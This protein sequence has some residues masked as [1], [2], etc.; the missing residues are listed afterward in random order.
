MTNY[1]TANPPEWAESGPVVWSLFVLLAAGS[2]SLLLW[3][4]R[5]AGAPENGPPV[6]D[7]RNIAAGSGHSLNPP[8]TPALVRG[9]DIE[10]ARI[11][12]LVRGPGGG[13]VV[14]CGAGGLGKT[15]VAAEAASRARAAGK[16]VVWI[17][18]RENSAQLA[19][20]LTQA[21][22]VLGLPES[23]LEEARSGRAPLVDAVWEQLASVPGW[24]I[25][26]DNV[27][28]PSHVGPGSEEISGYRGW[29]R[30]EGAGVLLITSRDT[31]PQTW[32]SEA[33]LM[34][35]EP[36]TDQAGGE[37]LM[38]TTPR[39][40]TRPQAEALAVRLGGVPLALN[41]AGSYLSVPTSRHRTF[42]AYQRA[43]ETEFGD[44]L[45]ATHPRAGGDPEVAR[46]L[47]RHTWDLSLDQLHREGYALARP[48]LQ[49][50]ALFEPAPIPRA[51]ITPA[52]L[53]EVTGSEATAAMVDGA[54]AGLHRY[55]LLGTG[56]TAEDAASPGQLLLHPLVREVT[57]HTLTRPD[58]AEGWRT[59]LARHLVQAATDT[60]G[61]PGREGWPTARLLAPHLGAL[62]DRTCDQDFAATRLVL[63]DLGNTLCEAGAV[64]EELL[65]RQN[66]LTA[67]D[68]RLGADH[69]DTLTSHNNLANA[70]QSAG[71]YH[72]A[73]ELHRHILTTFERTLGPD[74][75]ATLASRSN[76]A[77]SL[78][79]I[80][81]QQQAAELYRRVLSDRERVQGPDHPDTLASRNN[82]ATALDSI[83]EHQQAVDLHR[84]NLADRER[85]LGPDHPRT[86]DSR[87]NLASALTGLGDHEQAGVLYGGVLSDRERIQGPDHPDTLR[88][89]GNVAISLDGIGEHQ[90]AADL[91]RESLTDLVRILGPDHPQTLDS[92]HNLAHTFS[93]LRRHQQAADLHRQN[94]SDRE[95]VLGPDHPD[96]LRSCNDL[97]N[98]LYY[99]GEDRQAVDLYRRNL[100]DRER[101]LGPDHPDTRG[102]RHNLTTAEASLGNVSSRHRRLPW[103]R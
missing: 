15:T 22:L 35:L 92:R 41:A 50:L 74:H 46:R 77:L 76:L 26:V 29:L 72:Q 27:D 38:D 60:V 13:M 103:R 59:A 45:G 98:E 101:V 12:R 75:I 63:R 18:W 90:R 79:S 34:Q 71:E 25:V 93:S 81:E 95:R 33:V 11:E 94:L 73:A 24:L 3:E 44:L 39:A 56:R 37:L 6:T 10:L 48:V 1:V 32:G 102:S 61:I 28:T 47:V 42:T 14:V 78:D 80:G 65:L 97:A 68:R 8:A 88:S 19:H 87:E 16:A 53:A 4:R 17:R 51:L 54:L 89:R 66:V 86:L 21:A 49:L 70:L 62:L 85:I 96:T 52:L 40:G 31:S 100:S 58:P 69:P 30:A 43:L 82:L 20:D 57:A 64:F 99:L 9:R 36:L 67:T 84:R 83:G 23:R 55:G 5:L 2:L 7:L 91:R